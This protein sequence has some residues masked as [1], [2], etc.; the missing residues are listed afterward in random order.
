MSI[1]AAVC[2]S[3]R[4]R[5]SCIPAKPWVRRALAF[6]FQR[7][8]DYLP[9]PL[10]RRQSIPPSLLDL[11]NLLRQQLFARSL[12]AGRPANSEDFA[13]TSPPTAKAPEFHITAHQLCTMAA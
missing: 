11:L 5:Y 12:A 2:V 8:S 10:W 13:S 3:C 9:L 1:S 7:T 4:R 6:G